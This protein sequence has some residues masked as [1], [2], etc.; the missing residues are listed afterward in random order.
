MSYEADAEK[1]ENYLRDL[2]N[3]KIGRSVLGVEPTEIKDHDT[4]VSEIQSQV[5]AL[6]IQAKKALDIQVAFNSKMLGDIPSP[7][8]NEAESCPESDIH[9]IRYAL[10]AVKDILDNLRNEQDRLSEITNL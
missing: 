7:L 5:E 9:K 3:E 8:A 2:K 4:F 1:Y 10:R 6:H